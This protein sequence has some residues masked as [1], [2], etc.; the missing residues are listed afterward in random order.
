[1]RTACELS[2]ARL[3][4]SGER[5]LDRVGRPAA[6]ARDGAQP[7]GEE[8]HRIGGAHPAARLGR[9]AFNIA[10]VVPDR[11]ALAR[12]AAHEGRELGDVTTDPAVRE[13]IARE[14]DQRTAGFPAYLLRPRRFVVLER[15]FSGE[16]G[17]P[18]SVLLEAATVLGRPAS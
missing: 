7:V 11:V 16:N 14:I 8:P 6:I 5:E 4:A 3:S 15:G 2:L 12:W 9:R 13:L 17:M 10:L 1:M 18:P